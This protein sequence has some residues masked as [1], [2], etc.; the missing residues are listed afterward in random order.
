MALVRSAPTLKRRARFRATKLFGW[1]V[2]KGAD[3]TTI[4]ANV[5]TVTADPR[6]QQVAQLL[7]RWSS[8]EALQLTE[9]HASGGAPGQLVSLSASWWLE[10]KP[11]QLNLGVRPQRRCL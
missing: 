3:V 7:A 2:E 1:L 9:R 11:P 4:V 10:S 8:N 6:F 5:A